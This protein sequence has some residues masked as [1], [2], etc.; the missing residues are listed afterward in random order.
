MSLLHLTF[1]RHGRSRADDEN[2]HEGRYDSPLT[3]AGQQQARALAAHWKVTGTTFDQAWCS[4]LLRAHE[5][6]QIVTGVLNI[7]LTA[8]DLLREWDNGPL[9][10]M[11][12]EGALRR[13]PIP[14]FRHDLDAYTPDGGLTLA[15][16]R[17][18]VLTALELLW[19]VPV[20]RLL[21]IS[22]GGF[23]NSL[24]HELIGSRQAWFGFGDTGYSTLTLSRGSHTVSIGGVNL[25]PHLPD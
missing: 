7:P 1:L 13:Y 9:A 14:D 16:F 12:R 2:V 20:E 10:G 19:A 21:V 18:R 25:H 24:L 8:T 3:E 15:A 5:T 17:A 11:G 22:H 4:T 23:L 6:A